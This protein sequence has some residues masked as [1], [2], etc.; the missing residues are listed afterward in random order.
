MLGR[1]PEFLLNQRVL[2]GLSWC[3]KLGLACILI[4]AEHVSSWTVTHGGGSPRLGGWR[5]AVVPNPRPA[6]RRL[7]DD[8]K[9]RHFSNV[10]AKARLSMRG[11]SQTLGK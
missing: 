11:C 6:R 1:R 9:P 8:W 5:R 7:V 2:I 4:A 3:A 10:I